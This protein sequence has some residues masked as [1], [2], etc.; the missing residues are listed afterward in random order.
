VIEAALEYA[1]RGWPVLP[2]Q[3]GGKAPL[4]P[5]GL[6]DSSLNPDRI[7]QWWKWWPQA[8]IG[9][10]TG[11]AVDVIDVDSD[12]G[13][14]A[15]ADHAQGRPLG[16]GPIARTGRGWHYYVAVTGCRSRI[17]FLEGCDYKAAGGYV[18]CPPSLHSSG[19]RYRWFGDCGPDL[20]QPQPPPEWLASLLASSRS[21]PSLRGDFGGGTRFNGLRYA[22]AALRSEAQTVARA[23]EGSRNDTLNRAAFKMRRFVDAGH[24]SPVDVI[25]ELSAAAAAAGLPAFEAERTLASGLGVGR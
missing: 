23:P 12:E 14:H 8:N 18:I 9:I 16:W 13:L 3:P 24:L 1:A 21:R 22:L 2:C 5:N 17:R 4:S 7:R 15:L 10:R 19:R 11:I 20:R 6:L 25:E